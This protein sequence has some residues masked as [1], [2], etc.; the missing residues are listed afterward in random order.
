[1]AHDAY[2][3]QLKDVRKHSNADRLQC[4]TVFGTNVI[5]DMS[6]N[7]NDLYVYFPTEVQ[8]N[9]D[10]C[11]Q[12]NLLRK[13]D[14][15]GNNVG[16]YLDEKRYIRPLKLRGEISD[17]LVMP[18]KSLETFGDISQL[19]VGD[20]V[21]TF[22]GVN[23]CWKYIPPAKSA[24]IGGGAR[25]K[26]SKKVEEIKFPQHIDTPQLA[27]YINNFHNGDHII[28]TEKLEG[29]SHRS[30]LLP[31]EKTNWFRKLFKLAPK[32]V[33]K[34]FCGSRRVT[35][36]TE[37]GGYYGSND[38]RLD[39]HNKLVPHLSPN[40]EV[41]GEIV[42]YLGDTP[43]MG[44]VNT[45]SLK[46][47]KF[48]QT[49]GENMVFSYGCAPNEYDF[50]VYRIVILDKNGDVEVEYSTDQIIAWC[51]KHGFKYVPVL[52]RG[53]LGNS[54]DT[55][56][57]DEIEELAN[58]YNDG[59]STLDM[60]HWREGCVIRRENNAGKFDV[61]KSKNWTYRT[62]KGMATDN[63]QNGDGI[64]ADLLEEMV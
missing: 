60:R 4:A 29:T 43:I 52:Y 45:K 30:A 3:V 41:F 56:V 51:E 47:K 49:Y 2:V 21:T 57:Q 15:N 12:N 14:E 32:I 61:Y 33:Y 20:T 42:G 34:D 62:L 48:T 38:F 13:K 35:I 50:Y 8:I 25:A 17:G 46:D 7:E 59:P 26:K 22:N 53:Y 10:Y 39:I 24:R 1:M 44:S 5:V 64:S 63:M 31:V 19:K 37:D 58:I 16:G 36:E 6:A 18:I 28:I 9:E 55:K 11:V 40:M 54:Y 23:L 27:Y